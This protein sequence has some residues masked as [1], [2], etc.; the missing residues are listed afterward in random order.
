M[1]AHELAH[2]IEPGKDRNT[3]WRQPKPAA[4]TPKE[5]AQAAI[6][7]FNASA[8]TYAD[9]KTQLDSA[10]FEKEINDW[11]ASV[12]DTDKLIDDKLSGDVLMKRSLQSAYTAAI[13]ALIS[14]AA[15]ALSKTEDDLYR[16]NT[17]RIPM[18]AWQTPHHT[19]MSITSP[20]P[21]GASADPLSGDVSYSTK[22]GF[23][24]KILQD[25]TDSS[26]GAEGNTTII[27]TSQVPSPRRAE[28]ST[29]LQ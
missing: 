6:D 28:R 5:T 19:E 1:L 23:I 7:A 14:K 20:V 25:G 3:I 2:V 26:L 8:K 9:P 4:K 21:Q 22:N 27:V 11:Y 24:V 29:A 18:W 17:G 12:T 15:T 10:K 13:R 16:L